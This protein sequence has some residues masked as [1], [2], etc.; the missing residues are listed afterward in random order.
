MKTGEL[1]FK[2]LPSFLVQVMSSRTIARLQTYL[3]KLH[4][5]ELYAQLSPGH[6][7]SKDLPDYAIMRNVCTNGD[8]PQAIIDNIQSFKIDASDVYY[9]SSRR[10]L[11]FRFIDKEK[12][13]F[14]NGKE[15]PYQNKPITLQY[16]FNNEAHQSIPPSLVASANIEGAKT[17]AEQ[18]QIIEQCKTR[19]R[20]RFAIVNAPP[21][22]QHAH[23][24]T[25][26]E[27]TLH[28]EVGSISP[29]INTTTK[30]I[31]KSAWDIILR[32][33]GAPDIIK[34]KTTIQW[35]DYSIMLF[36]HT[37]HT[38]L[39]C[40][41]CYSNQHI[42]ARCKA[43]TDEHK[44]NKNVLKLKHDDGYQPAIIDYNFD[45]G[46]ADQ[47]DD[48]N[49]N[50]EDQNFINRIKG[51][52]ALDRYAL[53][54]DIDILYNKRKNQKR[55]QKKD[56][57]NRKRKKEKNVSFGPKT[58]QV[59]EEEARLDSYVG[60]ISTILQQLVGSKVDNFVLNQVADKIIPTH[61]KIIPAWWI[62]TEQKA[63]SRNDH[64]ALDP[65]PV[66]STAQGNLTQTIQYDDEEKPL[67]QQQ[68]PSTKILSKANNSV[69]SSDEAE[70]SIHNSPTDQQPT[71]DINTSQNTPAHQ[72]KTAT[73]SKDS[74]E[75][76]PLQHN[77]S[78][79]YSNR[80]FVHSNN[81]SAVEQTASE[82]PSTQPAVTTS[83]KITTKA[84]NNTPASTTPVMP[85]STLSTPIKKKKP[86]KK[87]KQ[88]AAEV[89]TN[90]SIT[91]YFA[92]EPSLK[93]ATKATLQ[94]TT[95]ANIKSSK[96]SQLSTK[97]EIRSYMKAHKLEKIRTPGNGH[98]L[99]VA[100]MLAHH[101]CKLQSFPRL[102]E[103]EEANLFELKR[104]IQDH[105]K[106]N[107]D[108]PIHHMHNPLADKRHTTG[109][110]PP[111]TTQQQKQWLLE[112]FDS[113]ANSASDVYLNEELWGSS[114]VLDT[115]SE[116]LS[117]I[118]YVVSFKPAQNKLE[119]YDHRSSSSTT[120][121]TQIPHQEW[122][123]IL[124]SI[125]DKDI[126]LCYE[127]RN[128]FSAYRRV[129]QEDVRKSFPK[130]RIGPS[131]ISY[132]TE[133]SSE[134][135]QC[136]G[137]DTY[138][139]QL[140]RNDNTHDSTSSI[141]VHQPKVPIEEKINDK[142]TAIVDSDVEEKFNSEDDI[143]QAEEAD[144]DD[145]EP[146]DRDDLE[147]F[148]D[149][150]EPVRTMAI[151][152]YRHLST[153]D[154]QAYEEH[155]EL[156]RPEAAEELLKVC[157]KSATKKWRQQQEEQGI[158]ED[159]SEFSNTQSSIDEIENTSSSSKVEDTAISS[160]MVSDNHKVQPS[161]ASKLLQQPALAKLMS[162]ASSLTKAVNATKLLT[163]A[164]N[165]STAAVTNTKLKVWFPKTIIV[166]TSFSIYQKWSIT[167]PEALLHLIRTSTYP[168]LFMRQLSQKAVQELGH[169]VFVE[170]I[171][172]YLNSLLETLTV[173]RQL[174]H[175]K[176]WLASMKIVKLPAARAAILTKVSQWDKLV[177][178]YPPAEHIGRVIIHQPIINYLSLLH[179]ILP[180][181]YA[182]IKKNVT[183]LEP[184]EEL[185]PFCLAEI[186]EE[187]FHNQPLQ[188]AIQQLLRHDW[189]ELRA[190]L[191]VMQYNKCLV[192][193][194]TLMY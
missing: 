185:P 86:T 12:A 76:I 169:F 77:D 30:T 85:D 121:I 144:I 90:Q 19:V 14:W 89:T 94:T 137:K 179:N 63:M 43:K 72:P 17:A 52:V 67:P 35:G 153:A 51:E 108:S 23:L 106:D 186:W 75:A 46:L 112:Y 5:A 65:K 36:H 127:N 6:R 100:I 170:Q 9:I 148:S 113:I 88:L 146:D 7:L 129:Q 156:T 3:T 123:N 168:L 191:K 183:F 47:W 142:S 128:H 114:A 131:D 102:N 97:K 70:T 91:K 40:S 60:N 174:Q 2:I 58:K 190:I 182:R 119:R 87:S 50:T 111:P 166:N 13:A 83:T 49:N 37:V 192:V 31:R 25:L 177:N 141:I 32:T 157:K 24:L 26:L 44:A 143:Q 139:E 145:G 39:P 80:S 163:E 34:G 136:R 66:S 101:N 154:L 130:T 181:F 81:I 84:S 82:Q 117:K 11:V 20:Y 132:I 61:Q 54:H 78:T 135:D 160:T 140:T 167:H 172:Q 188:Q 55:K 109:F 164:Q 42:Y 71:S 33:E 151:E 107:I 104:A 184:C 193:N 120:G 16:Y 194:K 4:S 155:H 133:E 96:A 189:T 161:P 138:T 56:Q 165:T 118:I 158:Y 103:T 99:W 18:L 45:T 28:L 64:D 126:V 150:D 29:S 149:L 152:E 162:P 22:L 15:L 122:E 178:L 8:V 180:T 187:Y 41:K 38:S 57:L 105:I 48:I 53:A 147:G 21:M 159:S 116:I 79:D 125:S 27:D 124:N 68:A 1:S 73:T 134:E 59:T 98:C 74:T 62:H 93:S 69:A 10:I 115:V 175:I 92:T 176:G 110:D 95:P 171:M 173:K